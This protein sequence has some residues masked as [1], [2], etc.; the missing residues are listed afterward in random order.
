LD[1]GSNDG[2]E[3][4]TKAIDCRAVK[5]EKAEEVWKK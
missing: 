2:E 5:R 1:Y 4:E 3:K